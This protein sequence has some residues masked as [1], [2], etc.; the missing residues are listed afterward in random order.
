MRV[1]A[2]LDPV[3]GKRVTLTGTAATAAEAEKLRTRFLAKSTPTGRP[4][5]GR[6]SVTP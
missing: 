5:R 2:G 3:T 4:G 6:R 1:D